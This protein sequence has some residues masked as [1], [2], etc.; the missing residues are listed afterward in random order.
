MKRARPVVSSIEEA[1]LDAFQREMI[2]LLPRLRRLAR[3]LCRNAADADDLVQTAVERALA[4]RGQ[5]TPGTRLDWWIMRIM[6]NA[7]I[8]DVR[9]SGRAVLAGPDEMAA[10]PDLTVA[11]DDLKT[12]A[13]A[14]DQAMRRLPPEQRMAIALVLL[15]GLSYAEAAEIVGTPPG[16][17]ASRLARGREALIADLEGGA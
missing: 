13:M 7:F 2:A 16:T 15:E 14:V 9:R 4:R 12:Q 6:R 5:W 11:G 10:V 3:S 8:D 1:Q 17:L